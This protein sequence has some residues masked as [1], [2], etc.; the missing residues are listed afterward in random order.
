LL[1]SLLRCG[2]TSSAIPRLALP[3]LRSRHAHHGQ[4]LS[5]L[6]GCVIR[7]SMAR[8]TPNLRQLAADVGD[9]PAGL[10]S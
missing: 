7:N 5:L 1:P 3:G 8:P 2:G 4:L 9:E 10:A 6:A